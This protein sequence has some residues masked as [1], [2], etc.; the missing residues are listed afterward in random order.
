MT[1][2]D[3]AVLHFHPVTPSPCH[4]VIFSFHRLPRRRRLLGQQEAD[5]VDKL[6]LGHCRFQSFGHH[7]KR[8]F[9][10]LVDIG[11]GDG[12]PLRP[13][14]ENNLLITLFGQKSGRARIIF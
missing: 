4:P 11:A 14:L 1:K 5:Q 3:K 10:H 9:F 8:R 12:D 7:R 13:I 6:L 2:T